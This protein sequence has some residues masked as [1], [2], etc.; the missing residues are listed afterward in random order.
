MPRT[1][2]ESHSHSGVCTVTAGSRITE[3]APMSAPVN[4]CFSRVRGSVPP[5]RFENSAPESV[6]GTTTCRTGDALISG[7]N[8][9]PSAPIDACS[10]SSSSLRVTPCARQICR[11]LTVSIGVP[12]PTVRIRS[13]AAARTA[14]AASTT[15]GHG[16]CA[17]QP[18]KSPA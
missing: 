8:R 6:V 7:T 3:R 5:P 16:V 15:L 18:S 12:P 13:G 2:V 10:A 14:L 1:P 4:R 11:I 9:L 17:M